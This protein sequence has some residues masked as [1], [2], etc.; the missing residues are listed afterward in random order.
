M[1][2]KKP[3]LEKNA[4]PLVM[5]TSA[6]ILLRNI[7]F[8]LLGGDQASMHP[9]E[10]DLTQTGGC[11]GKARITEVLHVPQCTNIGQHR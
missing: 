2:G 1:I 8:H 10:A 7:A 11:Y 3:H 6:L 4:Y 5:Y 9:H